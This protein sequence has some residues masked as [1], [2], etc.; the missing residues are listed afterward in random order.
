MKEQYFSKHLSFSQWAVQAGVAN[1][2]ELIKEDASKRARLAVLKASIGLP[3]VDVHVFTFDEIC[4]DTERFR[5]F[6]FAAG[7]NLYA[8]RANPK[9]DR[10][11]VLRNRKLTVAELVNW[12]KSNDVEYDKYEFSF[13]LHIDPEMASILLI[14]DQRI[15][16][17]G[18]FG[19]ILQLN[20]GAH[21]DFPAAQFQYD[22]AQW[23]TNNVSKGILDFVQKAIAYLRVSQPDKKDYL[24]RELDASFA[25][26]YIKGYF[27]IIESQ[28]S[29][30][31]FIDYNR[32]LINS[33][34]GVELLRES[35]DNSPYVLKG[36]AASTGVVKGLA[37]VLLEDSI[38]N[39]E[40]IPGEILVCRFT[41][42][43]YVPLMTKAAA[44]VTDVGG[45]LSHAAI[46]CREIKKPCIVGTVSGTERIKTGDLIEVDATKGIVRYLAE[47]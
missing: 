31:R 38:V 34:D 1:R 30:I 41:S 3:I 12:A 10:L 25:Q 15:V 27:E 44:V 35:G 39:A 7:E 20:K 29:G 24:I 26:D 6:R 8:L 11:P 37:R 2:E 46:V 47:S 5:T 43:E 18:I 40:L 36:Q 45:I 22:Y 4:T 23:K 32:L 19:G 16:G 9:E 28:A 33:L 14:T 21:M 42:P 17:E 13:E